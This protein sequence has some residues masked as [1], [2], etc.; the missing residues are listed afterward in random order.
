MQVTTLDY[1]LIGLVIVE[2]ARHELANRRH[3]AEINELL[4]MQKAASL[5][6]YQAHGPQRAISVP[7]QQRMEPEEMDVPIVVGPDLLASRTAEEALRL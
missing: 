4:A 2:I 6:E 7:V 5:A 1:V 3:R